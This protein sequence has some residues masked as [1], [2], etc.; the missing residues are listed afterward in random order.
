M[1]GYIVLDGHEYP[2]EGEVVTT[3]DPA[4]PGED[5][6]PRPVR[7]DGECADPDGLLAAAAIADEREMQPEWR[8]PW[9]QLVDIA[10]IKCIPPQPEGTIAVL[11]TRRPE[12]TPL[13]LCIPGVHGYV[14]LMEGETL[15]CLPPDEMARLG[16]V[17]KAD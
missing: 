10:D 15:D 5:R 1:T 3:W 2:I 8:T 6:G 12:V 13:P 17:R 14:Y 7:E 11:T 9:E 4:Q 16:W